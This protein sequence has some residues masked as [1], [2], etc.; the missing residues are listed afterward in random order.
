MAACGPIV[1][2]SPR[3]EIF[4]LQFRQVYAS[5]Q[6]VHRQPCR[7]KVRDAAM[8]DDYALG[9]RLDFMKLDA[10]SRDA[11][12]TLRPLI[13]REI[14]PALDVFYAQVK[15]F[16]ETRKFFSSE[17]HIAGAADRQQQHWSIIAAA[18]Y[19]ENYV[20]GVRTIGQV[21]ARI[22]LEPRWYIGGYNALMSGLVDAIA[23][24]MPFGRFD[25]SAKKK[26]AVFQTAIVKA[27]M[28]D[29]DLAISVYIEEGRHATSRNA[30]SSVARSARPSAT[31][32]HAR[33]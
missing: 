16:P 8:A 11:I 3:A 9:E 12:R 15:S 25:S 21:H 28:L 20:R 6:S 18:D 26:R 4:K 2:R 13:E 29:M 1:R 24:R 10:S 17:S 32:S 23:T 27:S 14:K 33:S 31:S 5:V 30:R 19:G 22:G 7:S